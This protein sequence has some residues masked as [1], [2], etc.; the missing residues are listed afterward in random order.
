[1]C[2]VKKG[3]VINFVGYRNACFHMWT[4]GVEFC[5]EN[6]ITFLCERRISYEGMELKSNESENRDPKVWQM[7]VDIGRWC[8]RLLGA[9]LF[10]H[11]H[12]KQDSR[13]AIWEQ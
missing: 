8:N 6:Y 2:Q 5:H 11:Q 9:V 1:M 4:P 13:G 3:T 12:Y 10:K 7:P